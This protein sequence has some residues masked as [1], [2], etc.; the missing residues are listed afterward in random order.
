MPLFSVT[1]YE[2]TCIA[3]R[4]KSVRPNPLDG[5]SGLEVGSQRG[6]FFSR[7]FSLA[8]WDTSLLPMLTV[9]Q[10]EGEAVAS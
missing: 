3:E 5:N 6:P 10:L 7:D 8:A 2:L 4:F 9:S 1:V